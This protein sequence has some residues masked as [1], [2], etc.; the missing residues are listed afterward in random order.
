MSTFDRDKCV[1]TMIKLS[2]KAKDRVA[3][4]MWHYTSAEAFTKIIESKELWMTNARFVNDTTELRT[5]LEKG[6]FES[7]KTDLFPEN[8]A[9]RFIGDAKKL[10]GARRRQFRP[11]RAAPM[12]QANRSRPLWPSSAASI[13]W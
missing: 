5:P 8:L 13:F 9:S 6:L 2:N 7:I 12:T 1:A 11:M 3:G 10:A 4:S